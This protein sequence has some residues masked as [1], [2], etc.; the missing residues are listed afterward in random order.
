MKQTLFTIALIILTAFTVTAQE[1]GFGFGEDEGGDGFGAAAASPLSVSVGGEVSASMTGYFDDFSEGAD[2]VQLGNIFSGKLN[3]SASGSNADALISLKLKTV[4]DGSASPIDIDEA[5]LRAYFGDF[6]LEAGFRKLTWGKAD[7]MGPLD[8]I[9]PLDTSDLTGITD[10]DSLKIGRPLIHA[11]YSI[12]D[13]TKFEGVFVPWYKAAPLPSERWTPAAMSQL[14]GMDMKYPD[15][16]LEYAQGGLRFTTTVGSSD[17]GFQYYYGRLSSPVISFTGGSPPNTVHFDYNPYHQI[18]ADY[19]QVIAGFN[20]RAELAANLTSDFDGDDGEVY[21]PALVWSL[22][23]DRVLVWDITL[24]LQGLGSL[25]LL[26]DKVGASPDIEAGTD[27]TATRII[28]A[29]SRPFLR[30]DLEANIACIWEIEHKDFLLAPGLTW[31]KGD[32]S[33]DLLFGIFGGDEAGQ[34]GQYHDNSFVKLGL[35]Y[36]F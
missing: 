7:M 34:F 36:M 10:P 18:G 26:D 20:I 11:S 6:S 21:N 9:N 33:I 24:N 3:F 27:M 5:F 1:F 23:F 14:A 15:P 30:G 8:V 12:G 31:T 29:L 22:G 25:R 32:I 28:A 16:T 4:F 35:T 17:F 2:A 13:F 19:A